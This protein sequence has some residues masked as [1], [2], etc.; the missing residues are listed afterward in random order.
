[1]AL[2]DWI[3]LPTNV[4]K[5]QANVSFALKAEVPESVCHF[6]EVPI[7]LQKSGARA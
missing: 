4:E 6:R 3:K 5:R 2:G 7:L 1:L